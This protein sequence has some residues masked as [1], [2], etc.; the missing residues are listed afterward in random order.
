MNSSEYTSPF[1]VDSR[2]H[3]FDARLAHIVGVDAAVLLQGLHYF[4]RATDTYLIG[5]DGTMRGWMPL[6]PDAWLKYFTYWNAATVRR[7]LEKLLER[8]LVRVEVFGEWEPKVRGSND[9]DRTHWLAIDYHKLNGLYADICAPVLTEQA[10]MLEQP[11]VPSQDAPRRAVRAPVA[12]KQREDGKLSAADPMVKA[13]IAWWTK[14]EEGYPNGTILGNEDIAMAKRVAKVGYDQGWAV[15][16][17]VD[18]CQTTYT[19]LMTYEDPRGNWSWKGNIHLGV[20]PKQLLQ[21]Y[22]QV[23]KVHSSVNNQPVQGYT[24]IVP[25]RK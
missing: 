17:V 25:R 21:W 20:M 3:T 16:Q 6:N 22:T 10:N 14:K 12:R 2:H 15:E 7:L 19:H 24:P 23:R 13:V 18:Y 9:T 4:L 1:L 11:V 5:G 8:E